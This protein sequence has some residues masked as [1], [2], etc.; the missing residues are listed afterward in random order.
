MVDSLESSSQIDLTIP[1]LLN[2]DDITCFNMY[3]LHI[4]Q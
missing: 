2:F 3:H 4:H 1:N